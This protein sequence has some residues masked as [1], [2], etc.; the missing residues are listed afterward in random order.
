MGNRTASGYAAV[1]PADPQSIIRAR[2]VHAARP[3]RTTM[4]AMDEDLENLARDVDRKCR[5]TGRFE[6]RSGISTTEYFDKYLFETDPALL[7]RIV[8]R[9]IPLVPEKT[10]VLGGLEM[11]GIPIVTMLSQTTGLP[12]VFVRKEP[13]HYGTNKL[14]EGIDVDGKN[15]TL[16]EDVIT[17]G[18]AVRNATLALRALS[19]DV[20]VVL[21][22]IDR[23]G[24]DGAALADI[25]VGIRSVF[26]KEF[27]DSI[28][29][30]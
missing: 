24:S 27:L 22:A 20:S 19:A 25:D 21:C 1:V 15:I 8:D 5:L 23:S 11:G 9:M 28:L 14:A 17:T 6:L 10:E 4:I 16:I 2:P 3:D 29:A 30:G 18:G 13:K 7:R 12:A 26:T